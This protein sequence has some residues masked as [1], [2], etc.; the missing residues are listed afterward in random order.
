V[1][2]RRVVIVGG[3]FSAA[4]FAVQ[5]LRAATFP[6]AISIIEPREHL[7][8]GLA[9]SAAD[10]DHR[11][12]APLEGHV[13]D[14]DRPGELREWV[15][16]AGV[17]HSD[18]EC[19]S[20]GGHVFLRRRDFGAFLTDLLRREALHARRGNSM[21]HV[22]D[23]A[24][25]VTRPDGAYRVV[26]S[27]GRRLEADLLVLA[28]GN[29]VPSLRPP[30]LP[31]HAGH[32]GI[33]AN[34]LEPGC[35]QAI[36]ADARV[37]VVGSGLTALDIV[38]TL[39]RREHRAE[40]LV[41]SRRGL[42]PRPHA[43]HILGAA[44]PRGHRP[45]AVFDPPVPAFL[46]DEPLRISAWSKALRR[47]LRRCSAAGLPWQ[48]SFD[49]LRDAVFKLWPQL[50]IEEKNRF[51]RRLRVYYDV[52]RFRC[53]PM[54]DAD[55]RWAESGGRV[56]FAAATLLA[57]HPSAPGG[58]IRVE[59]KDTRSGEPAVRHFDWVVNCTG[60]DPGTA[61]RSNPFLNALADRGWLRLDP[62]GIGVHV[63]S[64]CEALDAAG[65]PQPTVRA[66]GPPTAGVFGDPLGVP[67]ISGQVRRILP[68]VLRTLDC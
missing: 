58:G 67:F 57:V 32:P 54:N 65:N 38:S 4:C 14:P 68:D 5:L 42:R 3:G 18:D 8:R 40:L 62:T 59:M 61:W 17:L 19:R 7:G 13:I 45:P 6:V 28:T 2:P 34:P 33:I 49:A 30:F 16:G 26:T 39:L 44:A 21:E 43:P 60:L 9:Y 29:P 56:R 55:V 48:D 66:I 52:H 20:G 31:E 27:G 53:P 12:N 51:L 36:P 35:L 1:Q 46:R 50:P 15:E 63:G 23:L 37:L 24:V 11:L 41:V 22:R 47:E 25:A 64:H 10:A